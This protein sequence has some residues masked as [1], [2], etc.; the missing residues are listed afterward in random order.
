MRQNRLVHG[1]QV[2]I[3]T[4]ILL[5]APSWGYPGGFFIPLSVTC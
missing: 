1:V 3:W 5:A 2:L 4:Y